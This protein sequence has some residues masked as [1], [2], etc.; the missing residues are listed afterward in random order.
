MRLACA[1]D[2]NFAGAVNGADFLEW[3]RGFGTLYDSD[4]LAAWKADYEGTT[5][6]SA[7]S[8]TVP[9]PSASVIAVLCL[10]GSLR[11]PKIGM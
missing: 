5:L 3:Q 7:T 2:F 10:L 1:S 9:E 11:S 4:D 8:T 6:L